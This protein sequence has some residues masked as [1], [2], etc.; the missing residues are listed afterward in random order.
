MGVKTRADEILDALSESLD[1][2]VKD[3]RELIDGDVWG[4]EEYSAEY[5]EQVREIYID[6]I[7]LR[8][9]FKELR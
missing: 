5:R 4:W 6:L 2:P 9:R 1:E 3:L 7:R 8:D